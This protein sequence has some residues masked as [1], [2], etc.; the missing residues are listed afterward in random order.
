MITWKTELDF[1]NKQK[2]L[3]KKHAGVRR[4]SW[5]WG[6][7]II[8]DE[9][10][11]KSKWSSAIDLHKKLVAEVKSVN[12]W[13]YEVSKCS[14]QQALRDLVVARDRWKKKI[15]KFPRFKKKGIKDSFYL[16]GNIQISKNRIKLPIFG[17]VK[18]YEKMPVMRAKNCV[19]SCRAGRW[20]IAFKI[21]AEKLP[22]SNKPQQVVGVDLGIKALATL[23]TGFQ[24]DS[25]KHYKQAD[26]KLKRLQRKLSRQVK[27]SKNREKTKLRIAKQHYRV[28]SIR[29][30]I[31]HKLTSYLTKNHGE[32]VTEDLKVSN[33]L[34]NHNLARA[35][36]NGGFYEFKRQVAYKSNWYRT[37]HTTIGTFYPSSKTCS[38]CGAIKKTLKLS[39]R[40]FNCPCGF[41]CDRDL[42][43]SYNL[44][45]LAVSSTVTVCGQS[46]LQKLRFQ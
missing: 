27:G 9:I 34:K 29:Q 37:V 1:N 18:T 11:N 21:E 23:S 6:L 2:T 32:V 7:S 8:K 16:E 22:I 28:A 46:R 31:L 19:I 45:N 44:A 20:F 42:N 13:Y 15:A 4:H 41:S 14:P 38:S 26:K 43:A 25:P 3:A 30:D 33:M 40:V 24:V 10:E 5:N 12:D 36:A 39:E 35:I 17:W